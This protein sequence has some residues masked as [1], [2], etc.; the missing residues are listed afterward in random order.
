VPFPDT[1]FEEFIFHLLTRIGFVN[2]NWRKGTAHRS[3]PADSG[4]IKLARRECRA[5]SADFLD[6]YLNLLSMM[7]MVK[8]V[9]TRMSR[10]KNAMSV[11]PVE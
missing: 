7:N 3:S 2:V 1:D 6:T 11:V 5:S 4:G 8:A 9:N 10:D